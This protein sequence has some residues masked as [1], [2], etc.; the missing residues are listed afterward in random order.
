[1]GGGG[2]GECCLEKKVPEGVQPS[3]TWSRLPTK[4]LF[5]IPRGVVTRAWPQLPKHIQELSSQKGWQGALCGG[6]EQI[7][8][9]RR[10]GGGASPHQALASPFPVVGCPMGN[11]QEA[12]PGPTVRT[13]DLLRERASGS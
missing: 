1:M 7:L 9:L 3:T 11:D 5:V 10:L 13:P 2:G 8:I 6:L 12:W 4:D